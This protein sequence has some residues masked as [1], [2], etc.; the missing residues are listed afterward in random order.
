MASNS[1]Y[2]DHMYFTMIPNIICDMGLSANAQCLYLQLARAQGQDKNYCYP[3]IE[4]LAKQCDLSENTIIKVKQELIDRGLI[5]A[6]RH[7]AKKGGFP[8]NVYHVTDIWDE[9]E[10]Y[11]ANDK[12]LTGKLAP[13]LASR[14]T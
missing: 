11:F 9:N 10:Y 12:K 2:D 5:T 4:Y 6:E 7:R 1:N 3:S 13:R 14:I 8:Y